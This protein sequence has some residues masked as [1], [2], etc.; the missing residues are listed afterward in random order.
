MVKLSKYLEL[1]N[2]YEK[3]YITNNVFLSGKENITIENLFYNI[4]TDV[5]IVL[6]SLG[7]SASR[8]GSRYWKDAVFIYI[9]NSKMSMSICN[10]IYPTIGLKY[11]KT[12]ASVERAMRACFE[13]VLYN[14]SKKKSNY[15]TEYLQNYLL[16]P[17]NSELLLRIVELI[18]SQRFQK[19]KTNLLLAR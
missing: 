5:D 3:F 1:D 10:D 8:S 7:I 17:R 12:S 11:A 6:N 4:T 13:D 19:E 9:T 2:C 16:F 18:V 14:I 15:V